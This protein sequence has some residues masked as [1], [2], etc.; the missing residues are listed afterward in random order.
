M[1]DPTLGLT[2]DDLRIRVAEFLGIAYLG[3]NGDQAAQLPVDAH[4]LDLVTR[5]VNDGYRRFISEN[6]KWNFLNVPVTLTFL[7]GMVSA[8]H[9]RYFMPD[10]FYGIMLAPFTYPTNG[11]RISILMVDEPRM[12]ELQAGGA[13]SGYPSV[14]TVRPI[15]TTETT[16]AQR[17][18]AVFYP[19]PQTAQAVV[20]SYKRFPNKMTTGTHRSVAGFQHDATV[21]AAC[22]AEAENQRQD[23]AGP[24]EAAYQAALK[25]SLKIDARAAVS[26]TR[27]YG[28]SSDDRGTVGRRPLNYYGVDTYNGNALN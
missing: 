26:R 25:R 9:A 11:P 5:L 3:A 18:E 12:R 27:D 22:L 8:D 7:S 1:A 6:E 21:L 10:D 23:M 28:D 20:A 14:F 19:T 15:N 17:W 4:D 16:T 24:K 2:F 13:V